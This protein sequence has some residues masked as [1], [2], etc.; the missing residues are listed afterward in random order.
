MPRGSDC[1]NPERKQTPPSS[2]SFV[3]YFVTIKKKC[4][5]ETSFTEL[6]YLTISTSARLK[7]GTCVS[8]AGIL[9]GVAVFTRWP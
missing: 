7:Q 6:Y 8:G 9:G 4:L 3:R 1:S 5:I 2:V